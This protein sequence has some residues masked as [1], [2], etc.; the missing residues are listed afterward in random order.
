MKF[1]FTSVLLQAPLFAWQPRFSFPYLSLCR[2][3][4]QQS[5][6]LVYES[7][8]TRIFREGRT[9]TVRSCTAES[10]AFVRALLDEQYTVSVSVYRFE[11]IVGLQFSLQQLVFI[12]CQTFALRLGTQCVH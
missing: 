10:L 12:T 2:S 7:S 8:M 1:L 9:E 11:S 5:F 4:D 3:E 6:A